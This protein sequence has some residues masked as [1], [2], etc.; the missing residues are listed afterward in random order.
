MPPSINP[1][2]ASEER[3]AYVQGEVQLY[4]CKKG[5]EPLDDICI[6]ADEGQTRASAVLI[7]NSSDKSYYLTAGHVCNMPGQ[8]KDGY[9]S[10]IEKELHLLNKQG[11]NHI[12]TIVSF[13]DEKDLCLLSAALVDVS[14]ARF[15]NELNKKDKIFNVAAPA[16]IWSKGM[17]L[18]FHGEY[19]GIYDGRAMYSLVAQ[20]GSSGS[21]IF[22]EKGQIVGILGSVIV[23]GYF[24]AI[25]PSLDD[26][27]E[28]VH[29]N[30]P[31]A[32]G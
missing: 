28:F 30:A 5:A 17:V 23:P 16:G 13:D 27:R 24:L 20:P 29:K 11:D 15:A 8:E 4:I 22:N 25:S 7:H 10:K 32:L 9:Y 18:S 21:P 12:A 1:L 26:L 3:F 19:M 14:P 6:K 2:E 31:D